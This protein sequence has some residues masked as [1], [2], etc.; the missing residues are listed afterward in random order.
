VSTSSDGDGDLILT[1]SIKYSL[2]RDLLL[3]CKHAVFWRRLCNQCISDEWDKTDQQLA[4]SAIKQWRKRLT[5]CVSA[6]GGHLEHTL[7]W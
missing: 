2:C 6:G 1:P 3:Y 5:V 4:D 7:H